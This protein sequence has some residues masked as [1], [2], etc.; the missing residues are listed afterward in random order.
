MEKGFITW[1]TGCK[2]TSCRQLPPKRDLIKYRTQIDLA[3]CQLFDRI[4]AGIAVMA[5]SPFFQLVHENQRNISQYCHI[6]NVCIHVH[7][8]IFRCKLNCK[9]QTWISLYLSLCSWQEQSQKF[10]WN[11]SWPRCSMQIS[12]ARWRWRPLHRPWGVSTVQRTTHCELFF[13]FYMRLWWWQTPKKR[14]YD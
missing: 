9:R 8:A 10:G 12:T 3:K 14:K 2:L 11:S 6:R 4:K 13:F 7:V 5:R 1:E